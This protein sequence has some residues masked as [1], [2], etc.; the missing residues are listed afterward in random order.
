MKHGTTNDGSGTDV[1]SILLVCPRQPWE[2]FQFTKATDR[3]VLAQAY[4]LCS[5]Y[6][7]PDF[8]IWFCSPCHSPTSQDCWTTHITPAT[9]K[10]FPENWN[11]GAIQ[12]PTCQRHLF[13]D[14]V[15]RL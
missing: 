6:R 5:I 13:Y 14:Y 9:D 10:V 4:L 12:T 11:P 8:L 1:K 7:S 2:P 15:A 3:E